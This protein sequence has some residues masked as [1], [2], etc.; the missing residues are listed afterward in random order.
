L[1]EIDRPQLIVCSLD[2]DADKALD[3]VRPLVAQ[4]LG[5]QPHIAKAS[6]VK[7]SLIEEVKTALGGWPAKPGGLE[8][9]KRLI[10]DKLAR[11]I[12][13]SG[14]ADDCLKK[15][16]EYNNTGCT[17]PI[18]YPLGDDVQAMINAFEA[19]SL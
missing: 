6:G 2:Q 18:L 16:E 13:A 1:E 17:C 10:D 12:T 7:E 3:N 8:E 14:T 15:V 9:A 5:Q 11:L 19:T 4:Y